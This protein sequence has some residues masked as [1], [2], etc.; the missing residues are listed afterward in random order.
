MSKSAFNVAGR[1]LE[2]IVEQSEDLLAG[3]RRFRGPG[4]ALHLHL[5]H[6]A[7]R[8]A[9]VDAVLRLRRL[10]TRA[11]EEELVGPRF[12][13]PGLQ[14]HFRIDVTHEEESLRAIAILDGKAD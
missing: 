10:G 7:A 11:P 2:L 9:H 1:S 3:R 8:I 6:G 5:R 12:L 14:V 4:R 13:L